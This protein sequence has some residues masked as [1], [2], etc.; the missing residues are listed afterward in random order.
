MSKMYMGCIDVSKEQVRNGQVSTGHFRSG[1]VGTCQV[2]TGSVMTSQT[3]RLDRSNQVGTGEV[4]H[5][6]LGIYS[7]WTQNV[8]D[9]S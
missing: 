9:C 4:G 8:L 1:Y 2:R 3:G 7:F 5:V 6:M